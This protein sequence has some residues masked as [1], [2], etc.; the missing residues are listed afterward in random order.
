MSARQLR[1]VVAGALFCGGLLASVAVLGPMVGLGSGEL[2]LGYLWFGVERRTLF[3]IGASVLLAGI[4]GIAVLWALSAGYERVR[5]VL[6]NLALVFSSVLVCLLGM[7][8]VARA[9]SGVPLFAL[10]NFLAERNALLTTN[11]LN[12]YDP[13]LGWVLREHQRIAPNDP[14]GSLTTGEYGIRLNASDGAPPATGAVLASGDS[15]TAGSEVGDRHSWPSHLEQVL[16]SRVINAATGGWAADQIVLRLESLIPTLKPR[17]AIASFLDD[18]ILRAG[19]RVYGGANK[20]YFTIENGGLVHHNNPVPRYSGTVAETP[21]YLI[22]PSYSMLFQ[23]TTDR[24]GYADLWRKASVS[25]LRADNDPVEV[26]CK[27]LARLKAG[28]DRQGVGLLFL[29]QYP[30]HVRHSEISRRPHARQV[31]DCARAAGIATVDLWDDLLNVHRRSFE[32]YRGLWASFDGKSFGHMSSAGNELVARRLM[33]E[34]E[35]SGK[36]E[37]FRREGR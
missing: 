21:A 16:G 27:L 20:P 30:G 2:F 13:L 9:M 12:Q 1:P 11:T 4:L 14:N 36:I 29:M 8:L 17:L 3:W 35:R 24:L 23:W 32:E 31:L 37:A 28:A 10:R 34:I 25:Y 6:L 15:F 22:L 18:D 19:F 33:S 26:S 7:E 5:S